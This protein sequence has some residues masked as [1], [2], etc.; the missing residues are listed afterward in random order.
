MQLLLSSSISKMKNNADG[1]VVCE[2][3]IGL[4]LPGCMRIFR[5]HATFVRFN[6]IRNEMRPDEYVVW[7]EVHNLCFNGRL[8]TFLFVC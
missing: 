6:F 2:T 1:Q 7:Y 8:Y 5:K 3:D 4:T